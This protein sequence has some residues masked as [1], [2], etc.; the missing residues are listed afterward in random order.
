MD[1]VPYQWLVNTKIEQNMNNR[2]RPEIGEY[3]EWYAAYIGQT[4]G[5]DF[6]EALQNAD[7]E[8]HKLLVNMSD[9]RAEKA[10]APGKWT[11]K[12][13][14]QHLID[15]EWIFAYRA[16]RFARMD[17]TDLPGFDHDGYVKPAAANQRKMK[18]LLADQRNLRQTTTALF[19]SFS[20]EA[21][22]RTGT[23]NGNRV[24]VRAL[25]WIIAGH[26]LHHLK[27]IKE[28]YLTVI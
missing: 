3:A 6:M 15:S 22:L 12:D 11:I 10:Y 13:L 9:E 18:D 17:N 24:S 26:Q 8:L 28:R 16:L 7:E 1:V 20:E 25:A 5:N 27:I 4:S 2:T 14:L 19:S 21:L 23:A